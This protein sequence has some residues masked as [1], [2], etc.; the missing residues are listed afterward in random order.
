VPIVGRD[1][2]SQGRGT[3]VGHVEVAHLNHILPDGRVLLDDASFRVG[4][5]TTAA[6]VGPNGAGKTTLIRLIA[7]D[8][9]PQSGAVVSSG[10]LGVMR[11]FIGGIRGVAPPGSAEHRGASGG[12]SPGSAECRGHR[13]RVR[14]SRPSYIGR[15]ASRSR[16]RGAA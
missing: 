14:G 11:Q 4:E 3:E 16:R 8:L 7:G 9:D 6:L 10:G 12:R 1:Q 5:G 15:A 2:H 13:R